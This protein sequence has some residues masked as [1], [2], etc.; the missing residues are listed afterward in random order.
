MVNSF[1]VG[2]QYHPTVSTDIDGDFVIAWTSTAEEIGYTNVFA[3]RFSSAG[4]AL[5]AEFRVN[6]HTVNQQDEPSVAAEANGDFVVTWS[7]F[8]QDQ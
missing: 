3:R 4:T 5:A 6:S 7:S 2:N 1:L 8:D